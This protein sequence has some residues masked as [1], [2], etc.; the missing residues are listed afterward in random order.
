[1][2]S[3]KH[4]ISIH[5]VPKPIADHITREAKAYRAEG[6]DGATATIRAVKDYIKIVEAQRLDVIGQINAAIEKDYPELLQQSEQKVDAVEP[7]KKAVE[8]RQP[9][10]VV[11]GK[12]EQ[13]S[14]SASDPTTTEERP[15]QAAPPALPK[16]TAE[17][18][19]TTP[20]STKPEDA[21]PIAV[22]GA[23][24]QVESGGK[25]EDFGEKIG[26]PR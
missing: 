12:A 26:R 15:G 14:V 2:A 10:A 6:V 13:Q 9:G 11:E 23:Q 1:M 17:I 22:E 18:T 8:D 4:C 5:S 24:K 19:S 21:T 7:A 3:L 20:G 25:I 16:P